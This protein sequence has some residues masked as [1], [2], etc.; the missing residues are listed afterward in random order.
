M[1][2]EPQ[3]WAGGWE[4]QIILSYIENS[5]PSWIAGDPVSQ[6]D[7]GEVRK[8]PKPKTGTDRKKEGQ[9]NRAIPVLQ[10]GA[11]ALE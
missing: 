6:K 10:M 2:L 8:K 1:Y 4:V 9:T 3:H 7:K 11:W 5:L